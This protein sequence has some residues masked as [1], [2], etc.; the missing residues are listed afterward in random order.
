MEN[1]EF[2]GAIFG[3]CSTIYIFFKTNKDL[4]VINILN[5]CQ[6]SEI[7]M[8][9]L[10]LITL[11]FYFILKNQEKKTTEKERT[12]FSVFLIYF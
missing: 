5:N 4:I 10:L 11:I 7:L 9:S 8:S 1:G 2:G 12:K 6:I 3:Y